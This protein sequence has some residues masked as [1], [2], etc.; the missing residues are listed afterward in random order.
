MQE[1]TQNICIISEN[2]HEFMYILQCCFYNFSI[3]TTKAA[4]FLPTASSY[5][6]MVANFSCCYS[7]YKI[8][9]IGSAHITIVNFNSL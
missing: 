7:R 3:N 4:S 6:K 1:N 2:F 9:A 5:S 8:I